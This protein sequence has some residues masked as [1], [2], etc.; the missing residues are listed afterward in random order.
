MVATSEHWGHCQSCRYFEIEP[1]DSSGDRT[2]GHCVE[3]HLKPYRLRVI[4][5]SGCNE[6]KQGDHPHAPGASAAPPKA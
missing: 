3:E 6:F 5:S 1:S 2:F 4:G